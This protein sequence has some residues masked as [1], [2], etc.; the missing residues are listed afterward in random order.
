MKIGLF[1]EFS[2]PGKSEQQTYAEVLEQIPGG[3]VLELGAGSG[4][5]AADVLAELERLGR[6]P[7]RYL[8]LEVSADLR[9]R[10]RETLATRVP[11]LL[12]RVH[13]R[14][15]RMLFRVGGRLHDLGSPAGFLRFP[16]PT[17]DK[18]R[19]VRL[20]LRAFAKSDW[21]DWEG[22]SAEELVLAWA[23]PGVA[24]AIFEPL[25]R[26]KF[27]LPCAF[28]YFK[29]SLIHRLRRSHRL[30]YFVCVTMIAIDAKVT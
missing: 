25:C 11:H 29:L 27:E 23:G 1:T 21:S 4:V 5:M 13:W 3:D 19:F 30:P 26:L 12:P 2:Y 15:V 9:E 10:Q 8:I 14:R 7:Q 18:L 16:M 28:K 17:L 6:L 24:R 22:R 20:M